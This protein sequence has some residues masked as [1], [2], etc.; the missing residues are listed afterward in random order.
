M[1]GGVHFVCDIEIKTSTLLKD[2]TV[3]VASTAS[4]TSKTSGSLKV[5]G[6]LSDDRCASRNYDKRPS[7][8]GAWLLG[9][10]GLINNPRDQF[11]CLLCRM[12]GSGSVEVVFES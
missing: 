11:D 6:G 7:W 1:A 2:G 9:V 8:P 3:Y 12:S 10:S 4:A 5:G